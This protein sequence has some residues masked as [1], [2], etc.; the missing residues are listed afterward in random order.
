MPLLMPFLMPMLKGG[1]ENTTLRILQTLSRLQ[2]FTTH[3]LNRLP[4]RRL[5]IGQIVSCVLML[6]IALDPIRKESVH[7]LTQ[8]VWSRFVR[9]ANSVPQFNY[10][11]IW[12]DWVAFER[13]N[14]SSR[15]SQSRLRR[16][17]DHFTTTHSRK[18][19]FPCDE[20]ERNESFRNCV[21]YLQ[22]RCNQN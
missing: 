15:R 20:I 2:M 5:A 4:F 13:F 17:M 1:L 14:S 11:S 3:S 22:V 19:H 7:Q 18:S 8:V 10:Q 9:V 16:P 21:M 6:R 12:F